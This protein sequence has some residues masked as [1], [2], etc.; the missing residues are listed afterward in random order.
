M[1]KAAGSIQ[2]QATKIE[3]SCTGINSGI[4]RLLSE[5]LAALAEAE[6]DSPDNP[7]AGAAA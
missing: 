3:S 7:P 5:A 2:K 4:Q 1:K 6:A